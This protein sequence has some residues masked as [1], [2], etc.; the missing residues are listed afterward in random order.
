MG[1]NNH[2]ALNY[3]K[4]LLFN[5]YIHYYI[6]L[7]NNFEIFSTLKKIDFFLNKL[8]NNNYFDNRFHNNFNIYHFNN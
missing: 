6:F 4:F 2:I 5:E 7:K 1:N 8:I 3:Q